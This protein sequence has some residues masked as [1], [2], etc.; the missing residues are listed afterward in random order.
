M[1]DFAIPIKTDD[2]YLRRAKTSLLFM[3]N[4]G[5]LYELRGYSSITK[6]YNEVLRQSQADYLCMMH[7]DVQIL[8]K[9]FSSKVIKAFENNLK[10]GL[11]GVLGM[12]SIRLGSYSWNWLGVKGR[13][14][15]NRWDVKSANGGMPSLSVV[16][17]FC[18]CDGRINQHA[19]EYCEFRN[20]IVYGNEVGEVNEV[21][22]A[23]VLDGCLMITRVATGL[24]LDEQHHWHMYDWEYSLEHWSNGWEVGVI[25]SLVYHDRDEK[26]DEEQHKISE[27]VGAAFNVMKAKRFMRNVVNA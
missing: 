4:I 23:A 16:C 13:I 5:E 6:A 7:E 3:P 26:S 14:A 22:P 1:I 12:S 18:D 21:S 8:D 9:D 27:E 2:K 24:L 11:L 25:D 10:L 17:E 20:V 15:L 19:R